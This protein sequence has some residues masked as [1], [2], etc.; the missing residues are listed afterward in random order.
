MSLSLRKDLRKKEYKDMVFHPFTQEELANSQKIIKK[1]GKLF[2]RNLPTL[3]NVS[4]YQ[5]LETNSTILVRKK[6]HDFYRLYIYSNDEKDLKVV[7]RSI[8]NET[9]LINIPTKNTIAD[10]QM[11]LNDCG[12]RLCGIYGR[13]FN[14]SI[15]RREDECGMFASPE[16]FVDIK[17]M[18][19]ESFSPYTDYIPEDE[20]LQSMITNQQVLV[21]RY[22]DGKVGG[23]VIFTIGGKKG[24]INVWLD[25]TGNG[26]PLM[27]KTYNIFESKGV[28]YVYF[29]IN[30]QNKNVIVLHRMMGA[31]P[32]GLLDYT[33][34][35]EKSFI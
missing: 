12:F 11:V 30:S 18:L 14:K 17:E 31:K 21:N 3:D 20:E 26:I 10:Q 28:N 34:Y 13:Y 19:Y 24:Y 23:I 25:K 35:R 7:L 4:N 8:S 15:I 1:N 9:Y 32:D 6:E 29:W 27:Y 5:I 33:F 2:F 22:N 16:D